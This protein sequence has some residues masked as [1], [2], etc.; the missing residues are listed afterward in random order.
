MRICM[1][2]SNIKRI[3][4]ESGTEPC[5]VNLDMLHE[6][7]LALPAEIYLRLYQMMKSR[8]EPSQMLQ[9]QIYATEHADFVP[10]KCG[11]EKSA[12]QGDC[13]N[14]LIHNGENKPI[15]IRL[16]EKE[17][18]RL[19]R[20]FGKR[21]PKPDFIRHKN[22]IMES[23]P[24]KPFYGDC[25]W[26]QSY[27]EKGLGMARRGSCS[28]HGDIVCGTGYTCDDFRDPEDDGTTK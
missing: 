23:K 10:V 28:I 26:C 5:D 8:I 1:K 13:S 2:V 17:A 19:M 22:G 6:T 12:L 24:F 3:V 11:S 7:L 4:V 15:E 14:L 9:D 20:Q 18:K 27:C 16:S 25:T 21:E